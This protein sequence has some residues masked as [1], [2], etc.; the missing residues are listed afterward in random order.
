MAVLLLTFTFRLLDANDSV[1]FGISCLTILTREFRS[2]SLYNMLMFTKCNDISVDI[3][4][5]SIYHNFC[6]VL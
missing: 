5:L 4:P 6:D 1:I 3:I 2:E